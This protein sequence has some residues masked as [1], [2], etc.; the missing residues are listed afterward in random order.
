MQQWSSGVIR[1]NGLEPYEGMT[2]IA[3]LDAELHDRFGPVD[4]NLL[5]LSTRYDRCDPS[6]VGSSLAD[7]LAEDVVHRFVYVA[8]G[9]CLDMCVCRS[10]DRS[11]VHRPERLAQTPPAL[12]APVRDNFRGDAHGDNRGQVDRFPFLRGR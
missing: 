11:L 10:P 7:I 5:D 3:R 4:R 12:Q 6:E 8:G 1:P 2:G 9:H